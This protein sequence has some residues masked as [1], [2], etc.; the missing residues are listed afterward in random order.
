LVFGVNLQDKLPEILD[1]DLPD[2]F[3]IF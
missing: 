3:D 1:I 2:I